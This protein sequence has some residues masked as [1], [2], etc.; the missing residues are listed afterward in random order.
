MKG[1]G[2]CLDWRRIFVEEKA[3]LDRISQNDKI[4]YETWMSF[5]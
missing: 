5:L 3:F 4:V 2:L 1:R